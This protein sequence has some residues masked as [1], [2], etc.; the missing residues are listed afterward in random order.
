[1]SDPAAVA[2]PLSDFSKYYID[3]PVADEVFC[4]ICVV[5]KK[6]KRHGDLNK[7]LKKCHRNIIA[8]QCVACNDR[9]DDIR[10]CKAHQKH[11]K[12]GPAQSSSEL[13]PTLIVND[14]IE[15]DA[16]SDVS[17]NDPNLVGAPTLD[18][19]N[20]SDSPLS[21]SQSVYGSDSA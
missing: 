9:F 11:L 7:H 21:Q 16:A 6:Y 2:I 18:N 4:N 19:V 17:A 3:C 13:N 15:A 12:H 14:L 1:M 20:D 8:W 10:S 5:A